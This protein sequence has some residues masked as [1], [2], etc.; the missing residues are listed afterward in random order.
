VPTVAESGFSGFDIAGWISIHAPAATPTLVVRKLNEDIRK[1][2]ATSEVRQQFERAMI[3]PISAD[4]AQHL[5][6]YL[7]ADHE[8]WGAVI[9]KGKIQLD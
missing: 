3:D 2:L 7:L 9:R 5:D 6:R 4:Q 1:V 8:T